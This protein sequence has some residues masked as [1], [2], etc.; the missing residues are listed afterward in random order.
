MT[1]TIDFYFDFSSSYSYIAVPGIR[2]VADNHG[3]AVALK[4]IALGAIFKALDHSI[5]GGDTPKSRYIR[6]DVARSAAVAGL[7]YVWPAPFPFN[8]IPAA[9]VFWHL[10]DSDSSASAAWADS[11]FKAAFG[12]GKDC[13]NPQVLA[14]IAS[15]LGHDPEALVSATADDKVKQRLKEV[16]NEAM[17][18]GVFGA[19]TFFVD[20]EMFWGADRI[21]H[22]E[23]KLASD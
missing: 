10:D 22:I 1:G 4:P 19:P 8:S 13:S 18:R 2:Q 20:D 23:N 3:V 7:P 14:D 12:E 5:P 17:Q 16:T 6:H 9:R 21:G 11:V 15:S